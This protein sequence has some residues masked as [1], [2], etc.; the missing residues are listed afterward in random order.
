MFVDWN[1]AAICLLSRGG[2]GGGGGVEGRSGYFLKYFIEGSV[3][4]VR[5]KIRYMS[6]ITWTRLA[7]SMFQNCF[8]C[9]KG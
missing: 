8:S 2:G 6:V 4:V 3:P 9:E 5:A 7:S 1:L